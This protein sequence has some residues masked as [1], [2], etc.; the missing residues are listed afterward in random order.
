MKFQTRYI[1]FPMWIYM[2]NVLVLGWTSSWVAAGR[3]LVIPLH[4]GH[5]KKIGLK[6]NKTYP[7]GES[8]WLQICSQINLVNKVNLESD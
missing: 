8:M 1:V 3:W 4:I 5:V 7:R 6:N 2:T